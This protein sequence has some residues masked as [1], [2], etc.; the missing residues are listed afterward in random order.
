MT[1]QGRSRRGSLQA[2][3]R[4]I[5]ITPG[6][7]GG[8][9]RISGRRLTVQS[10]ALWHERMGKSVDEIAA[11]YDLSHSEVHAA[12][13]YYFDHR[14]EIDESMKQGDAFVDEQKRATPSKVLRK[15]RDHA[16]H[17]RAD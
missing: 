12:L 1:D 11:E 15:L 6:V 14:A 9:P 13:A 3:D 8:K 16:A 4:H 10:I 5:E 2:L 17:G 7:A